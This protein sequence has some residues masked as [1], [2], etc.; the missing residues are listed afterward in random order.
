MQLT[1]VYVI[2]RISVNRRRLQPEQLS[3]ADVERPQCGQAEAHRN[4]QNNKSHILAGSAKGC[5]NKRSET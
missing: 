3:Q 1:D 5:G 4:Q 2:K